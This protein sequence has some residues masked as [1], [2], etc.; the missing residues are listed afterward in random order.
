MAYQEITQYNSPNYTHNSHAQAVFGY[1]RIIK[2]V[3][4]HWWGDPTKK[5][6]FEGVINW[7]C[8]PNGNSSA[9]VV[10][11]AGRVAWII[12]AQH[13]AW[14][15]GS[16]RGNAQY[17]GYECN[18]RL[19]DG[20]YETMGEFHYN[21]EKAYGRRLEIRLHKEFSQTQ[22]A[23]IDVS[24]I[25]QIADRHHANENKPAAPQ[26]QPVPPAEKLEKPIIV[27]MI[28]DE[29]NLWNLET[30]PNFQSVKKYKRGDEFRAYAKIKFGGSEYFVTEYSYKKGIKNGINSKD[31]EILPE[32]E[33][34]VENSQKTD[35][36]VRVE[37]QKDTKND[38]SQNTENAKN[39]DA[40]ELSKIA[41]ENNAILKKLLALV[42]FLVEKVKGIFK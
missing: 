2:G 7:L 35:V 39:Q 26:K 5:P 1:P 42:E 40:A 27:K 34:P 41:G 31:V 36:E 33:K 12:D 32:V 24:R 11:E 3:V 20:D 16:G 15:A 10:G 8:R 14:H 28:L 22:C 29:V 19:S 38:M 17:L 9:H 25:R 4:Y 23:P 30:N 37:T 18:P 21:V 13:A 6:A